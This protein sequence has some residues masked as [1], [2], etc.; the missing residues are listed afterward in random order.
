MRGMR[1]LL[2]V[3][4]FIEQDRTHHIYIDTKYKPSTYR[5]GDML[6]HVCLIC[7]DVTALYG[8]MANKQYMIRTSCFRQY[9]I[10]VDLI[11][12]FQV[13]FGMFFLLYIYFLKSVITMTQRH[14]VLHF[15]PY[16]SINT[17]KHEKCIIKPFQIRADG[18][19]YT[20]RACFIQKTVTQMAYTH[21]LPIQ[22][23][24]NMS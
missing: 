16:L 3:G 19:P 7:Y 11:L 14:R 5:L 18:L 10:L 1:G 9:W 13:Y 8:Q 23:K 4:S 24:V 15:I 21:N 2:L 20:I 6:L 22:K 12:D 17:L